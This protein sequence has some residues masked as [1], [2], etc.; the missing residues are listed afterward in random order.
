MQA[1]A[2]LP[3]LSKLSLS[4]KAAQMV[5][6]DI[7][8]QD[9]SEKSREHLAAYPWNGVILFAKNVSDRK[10]VVNLVEQIHHALEIPPLLSVDQEGGLVDRFRFP[11]MTLS[12]GAMALG[13][14]DDEEATF[15]AH[16]IMGVELA[17]L[18]IHL[19][20]APCL[21]VNVNPHNPI[22]G[23][24]SF[25]EDPARVAAHG[26]A[27]IRGLQ[28]G[29]VA[30]NGK[31]FPGHGDTSQ[32]SHIALPTVPHDLA[33]L[34]AVELK[35]FAAAVKAGVET[36]MTAHVTFPAI[37]P[38]PGTPATLSAPALTELLR[39][40]MGFEGV[41]VTDS[42]AMQA[43]AD[44]WGTAE[45][46]VLS[47]EAGADLILACGSFENQLITVRA[48]VEA[49]EQ[50]RLSEERLDASVTR[51]LALKKRYGGRPALEVNY[52]REDH[53]KRMKAIVSRTV[54]VVRN[55]EDLLPLTGSVLVL[56]PD[57]LPL[58]PLGEMSRSDSLTPFLVK[59]GLKVE[60]ARY[61]VSGGGPASGEL[62]S[63]AGAFDRAV[64]CVY[65][66][67]RLPDPQRELAAKVIA[68]NPRTV[69]VSLSS[70]YLLLD[71]PQSPA[72]V[73][74]YNYTPYSLEA[75]ALTLAGKMEPR[76]ILP[77]TV[78]AR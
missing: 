21:D 70:P 13:A 66:R 11:E 34:E 17:S 3:A 25:S 62:A 44:R 12:P 74:A 71:V 2:T 4:Q 36:I 18:G 73:L 23:V 6:I 60:E 15:E 77:V 56:S 69:V 10:Q 29:G 7:P 27:A 41:I 26:A 9:L 51:I 47:V 14:A 46:A 63:R 52:D 1:T 50:G 24:R 53:E 61:H 19:D 43:I 31:H 45:A 42:M 68:A 48:I 38:R 57:L 49:V 5:M 40:K 76:G 35:P 64:M 22:I 28:A 54:T 33:R 59:A 67:D 20:F 55:R 32:D 39:E 8:D 16:R 78:P 75:L 65:G 72:Y 37:D 58:T 30:A